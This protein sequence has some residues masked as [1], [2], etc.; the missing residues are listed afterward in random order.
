MIAA[1]ALHLGHD[2]GGG[3]GPQRLPARLRRPSGHHRHHALARGY[4][5][6][7]AA[8][9]DL[10]AQHRDPVREPAYLLEPVRDVEGRP[11]RGG[12]PLDVAQQDLFLTQG[13]RRDRLV[14]DRDARLGGG[15]AGD[16]HELL[17]GL[18]RVDHAVADEIHCLGQV[19]PAQDG[20]LAGPSR[21]LHRA[22][23]TD[24]TGG[25]AGEGPVEIGDR[26]QRV[27]GQFHGLLEDVVIGLFE[28]E[29][30]PEILRDGVLEAGDPLHVVEGCIALR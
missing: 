7:E 14:E 15:G 2:L 30:D 28:D 6:G 1:E 23:G 19:V 11:A 9:V 4:P 26:G 13:Q 22:G 12:E 18:E 21:V 5:G 25:V 29:L 20:D 16:L 17:L 24:G 8:H 3:H 10:I 27:F